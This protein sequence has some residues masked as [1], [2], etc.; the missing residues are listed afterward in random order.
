M[1][2]TRVLGTRIGTDIVKSVFMKVKAYVAVSSPS[3]RVYGGALVG[4]DDGA[5]TLALITDLYIN[6]QNNGIDGLD[7]GSPAT[8][9]YAVWLIKQP[10]G[11]VRGLLSLHFDSPH[12]PNGYTIKRRIGAA[13]CDGSTLTGCV[14]MGKKV[15]WHDARSVYSPG[16]MPRKTWIHISLNSATP[17]TVAVGYF[18]VKGPVTDA[19][20]YLGYETLSNHFVSTSGNDEEDRQD[21]SGHLTLVLR[22]QDIYAYRGGHQN[23]NPVAIWVSGYEDDL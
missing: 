1:A 13:Y 19:N 3:I 8:G 9:W 10:G 11:S 12:L 20:L 22:S 17:P 23:E 5:D 6:I 15:S 18:Q 4:A 7:E 16:L 2:E 21:G 14:Q